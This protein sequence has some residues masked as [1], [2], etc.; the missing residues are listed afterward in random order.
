RWLSAWAMVGERAGARVSATG[1][2]R[3]L[4]G[5]AA[6]DDVGCPVVQPVD[7][8][9]G[10]RAEEDAGMAFGGVVRVPPDLHGRESGRRA[11]GGEFDEGPEPP[12]VGKCVADGL[13]APTGLEFK[14]DGAVD[15]ACGRIPALHFPLV[16]ERIDGS[17]GREPRRRGDAMAVDVRANRRWPSEGVEDEDPARG[18]TSAGVAEVG[19]E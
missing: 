3:G 8:R 6:G 11:G 7:G 19:C 16:I 13:P 5:S 4:R 17:L 18:K 14:V 1:P 10:D 9:R 15:V 12:L 2:C